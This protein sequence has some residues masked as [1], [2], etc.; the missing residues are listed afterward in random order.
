MP[1]HFKRLALA[2]TISVISLVGTLSW[3]YAGLAP[4]RTGVGQE[5][6]ARLIES[7]EEVQ[8]KEV[9]RVIWQTVV[10][11]DD[12]FTGEA[13]RT[14][15][16]SSARV[17][18]KSGAIIHLDPDSLVVLEQN[19]KGL[20]LDFL[21]G[22]MFVQGGADQKTGLTLK[23]GKG[24]I[25]MNGADVNLSRGQKG[26]VDLE[27]Y[28]GQLELNQGGKTVA[29]GQDKAAT[30]S[31]EGLSERR[32]QLRLTAPHAGEA[33]LLNFT[34]GEKLDL[35]WTALPA[36]YRVFVEIGTA[37]GTLVRRADLSFDGTAGRGALELKP[38]KWV[39]RLSAEAAGQPALASLVT[40]FTVGARVA[41][42]LIEPTADSNLVRET[43]DQPTTFRWLN[44]NA[45]DAQ[46]FEI[47]RAA[48]FKSIVHRE[49]LA[50]DAVSTAHPLGDG[51]YFWRVTGFVKRQGLAS[52]IARVHVGAAPEPR[53][54]L[55][56][57]ADDAQIPAAVAATAGVT[58][59]WRGPAGRSA[60]VDVRAKNGGETI[61]HA[62]TSDGSALTKDLK[63]GVYAWTVDVGG[64]VSETFEFSVVATPRLEFTLN[65]PT[66][67]YVTDGPSLAVEWR[68]VPAAAEY[69]YRVTAADA[70]APGPWV[71]VKPNK[72]ITPLPADGSYRVE[73]EARDARHAVLAA[74][75]PRLIAVS[76]RPRLT[77]PAVDRRRRERRPRRKRHPEV[78]T[79]RRRAK[80]RPRIHRRARPRR[81]T[82]VRARPGVAARPEAGRIPNQDQGRRRVRPPR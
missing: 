23:T 5:V 36:G 34:K 16:K 76:R 31:A 21:E 71:V 75:E 62:E 78:G 67:G 72:F 64:E 19:A 66:Y 45:F 69:A 47:A 33:V 38:G 79:G 18:L 81:A 10:Q 13:I 60:T 51:T 58:F 73:V 25:T 55:Q 42:T 1:K 59:A 30:L 46:I 12:L 65:E 49:N 28:R 80:L 15:A 7:T 24:D 44:R 27:V 54:Q 70:T 41:P 17:R 8:R 53:A 52:V 26:E 9:D 43:P 39:V 4:R 11:N 14:G 6:V 63:P 2:F 40:P 77:A 61:F 32:D 68:A 74:A 37:R 56:L 50:P 82:Q 29:L 57:P 3:Y 20:S 48:D 35:G 22:N